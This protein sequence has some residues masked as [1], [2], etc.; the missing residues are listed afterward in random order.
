MISCAL[1]WVDMGFFL[2]LL[3]YDIVDDK[4]GKTISTDL[5]HHDLGVVKKG[6]KTHF[7]LKY[8]I[9]G[10]K[11]SKSQ[12]IDMGIF[13]LCISIHQILHF[14]PEKPMSK[15]WLHAQMRFQKCIFLWKWRFSAEFLGEAKNLTQVFFWKYHHLSALS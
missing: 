12:Y 13:I 10:L 3:C 6:L 1:K 11:I 9:L 7:F 4:L 15:Y 2:V 8:D 5:W 14:K